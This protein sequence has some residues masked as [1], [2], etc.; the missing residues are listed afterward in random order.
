MA[1]FQIFKR[2]LQKNLEQNGAHESDT[3]MYDMCI[4]ESL[5][6]VNKFFLIGF[7]CSIELCVFVIFPNFFHKYCMPH[8]ESNG[9]VYS[10]SFQLFMCLI[11]IKIEQ[12]CRERNSL[13]PTLAVSRWCHDHNISKNPSVNQDMLQIAKSK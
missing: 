2:Q 9:Q 13:I 8:F 11:K 4:V 3:K 6:V 12:K 7:M 1:V 10:S 5:L